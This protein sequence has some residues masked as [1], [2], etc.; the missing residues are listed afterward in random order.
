MGSIYIKLND[1]VSSG[2]PYTSRFGTPMKAETI[3]GNG[4]LFF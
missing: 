1:I 3:D 2:Q 4:A